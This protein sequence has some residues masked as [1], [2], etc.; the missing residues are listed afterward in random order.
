[1]RRGTARLLGFVLLAACTKTG[2][3]SIRLGES[4]VLSAPTAVGTAPMVAVGPGGTQAVAWVSA[5]NGGTDGRLY[6]SVNAAAP[7]EI[8]DSLGPVQAHGEAPPKIAFGPSGSLYAVYTVGKE[9]AG[10][11]FPLSALR[12]VASTDNGKSW[13]SP[14]TVTDGAPFGSHSFHA[15]HVAP[16]G[17]VY[18]SW[19][20]KRE[21][22]ATMAADMPMPQMKM[23]SMQQGDPHA[24]HGASTSWSR[25]RTIKARRGTSRC[26]CMRT[27]GNS[28]P[29]R[30]PARRSP[31]MRAAH[32][33]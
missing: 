23:V 24:A 27:I 26:A 2:T 25:A 18:V 7:T 10:E 13:T 1:M 3:P 29:V 9:V 15:L 32:F 16:N 4:A 33:T 22:E 12:I 14:V 11:R 28:T 8:R 30:T 31:P 21:H 6:V 19:L 20:G 17:D 5:P